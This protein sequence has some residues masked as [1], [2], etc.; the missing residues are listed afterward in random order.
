[1]RHTGSQRKLV[2]TATKSAS[3]SKTKMRVIRVMEKVRFSAYS[4]Q[5][6]AIPRPKKMLVRS[7]S[8]KHYLTGVYY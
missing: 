2:E 1:M 4:N 6:I 5:K 7:A 8:R 3:P